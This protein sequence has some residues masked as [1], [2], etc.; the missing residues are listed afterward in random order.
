M[1]TAVFLDLDGTLW[2]NEVIPAS[3]LEAIEKARANGH[4]I[5]ANTGRSRSTAWP[6]LKN[7]PLDGCVYSAGSEIWLHGQRFFYEPMPLSLVHELKDLI[8]A[9]H[10]GYAIEGSSNTYTNE[11]HREYIAAHHKANRISSRFDSLPDISKASDADLAEAMKF[12]I[13]APSLDFLEPFMKSHDLV[14]TPFAKAADFLINGEITRSYMNK[15]TA[16][17]VVRNLYPEELRTM[18]IGDSENDLPMIEGA[19]LGVAMG[20]GTPSAKEAADFVTTSLEEDGIQNAF[21]K[22]GLL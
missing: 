6:A 16:M 21:A 11:K 1:K 18:A 13:S 10:C 19:D 12:S 20:N 5:F 8:D 4:L 3:A 2:E 14:F 15:A 22:A 17:E 7:V 9:H